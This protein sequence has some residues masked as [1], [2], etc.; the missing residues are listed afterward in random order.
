MGQR[1]HLPF[2]RQLVD[3][4]EFTCNK[5]ENNPRQ[6]KYFIM[7]VHV[8]AQ[9][10]YNQSGFPSIFLHSWDFYFFDTCTPGS[11]F[12]LQKMLQ[13]ISSP[14]KQLKDP[15]KVILCDLNVLFDDCLWDFCSRIQIFHRQLPQEMFTNKNAYEFYQNQ[16]N[17]TK[18]V[19]CLKKIFQR[20]TQLQEQ[21]VNIYYEQ[22]SK[23]KNLSQSPYNKIY[24]MSKDI[25]CGKR[26]IGLVDSLQL[27]IRT[28]FTNF[29][30]NILKYLANDY[31]LETLSKLSTSQNNLGSI[32]SLID[33]SSFSIDD[34]NNRKSPSPTQG[35]FQLIT[36][37]ACIL[38]MPLYQLFHETVKAH[39]DNIKRQLIDAR[40]KIIG[41][42]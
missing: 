29:V 38:Q 5:K 21:I 1:Q 37:Y 11:A 31:G 17:V 4:T 19:E 16:T 2:V 40:N 15:S 30:S 24:Q 26:F 3:K 7:L 14:K 10:L 32:L 33:Y 39:A 23:K 42:Y 9:E 8:S 34:E 41:M 28:S 12:H 35:V 25:L 6:I 27:Q 22:M 18:R 36:H 20:L 13:I